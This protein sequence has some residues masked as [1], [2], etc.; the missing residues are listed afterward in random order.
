M[1]FYLSDKYNILL[2]ILINPVINIADVQVGSNTTITAAILSDSSTL[3]YDVTVD[4]SISD[5]NHTQQ[6]EVVL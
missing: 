3:P 4:V 2:H 5:H 6:T 1:V